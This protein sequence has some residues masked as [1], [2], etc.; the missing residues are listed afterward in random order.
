MELL[1]G[2]VSSAHEAMHELREEREAEGRAHAGP[3]ARLQEL[4][5]QLEHQTLGFTLGA[6]LRR[7]R[8]RF[9]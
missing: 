8:F 6:G 2:E 7:I 5:A 1:R 4:L 9:G 3:A